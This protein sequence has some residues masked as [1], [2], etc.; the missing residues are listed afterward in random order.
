M[1]HVFFIAEGNMVKE[2]CRDSNGRWHDGQLCKLAIKVA[3]YSMLSACLLAREAEYHMRVY[4]QMM[5]NT[6]QEYGCKG[7][8]TKTFLGA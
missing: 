8:V 2:V 1:I 3:P 4:V 5:D 7:K 6:I